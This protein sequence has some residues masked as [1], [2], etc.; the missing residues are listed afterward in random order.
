MDEFGNVLYLAYLVPDGRQYLQHSRGQARASSHRQQVAA[1][2]LVHQKALQIIVNIVSQPLI[3]LQGNYQLFCFVF[4]SHVKIKFLLCILKYR[5]MGNEV[6]KIDSYESFSWGPCHP[7]HSMA[8]FM[9]FYFTIFFVFTGLHAKFKF[10]IKTLH[11][12][13]R[14]AKCG[15]KFGRAIIGG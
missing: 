2:A 8:V 1:P 15:C 11:V 12:F 7:I 6:M 10:I 9:S 4:Q 13:C 3:S 14:C 5:F